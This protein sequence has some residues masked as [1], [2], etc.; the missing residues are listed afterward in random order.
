MEVR[1]NFFKPFFKT[2]LNSYSTPKNLDLILFFKEI[3]SYVIVIF[4]LL[5]WVH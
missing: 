2:V 3:S 5:V 4:I 1:T